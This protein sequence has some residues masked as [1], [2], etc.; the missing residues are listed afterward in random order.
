MWTVYWK[1]MRELMRDTKVL[2]FTIFIPIVAIPALLFGFSYLAMI[3]SDRALHADV[4]YAVFG[5]A[6]GSAL[7]T[8]LAR[9]PRWHRVAL[10]DAAQIKP[11]IEDGRIGFALVAAPDFDARTG[12]GAQ[13]AIGLVFNGSGSGGGT[14]RKRVNALIDAHNDAVRAQAGALLGIDAAR[15]GFLL[16]PVR[17][18]ERPT[19]DLRE[20][21]GSLLGGLLPYFLTI[22]CLLAAMY[23][24]IDLGAGEKERGTLETLLLAP[25]TRT[26]LVVAK[27][28]VLFTVGL[29][30][31]LLM[32]ISMGFLL[33]VFGSELDPGIAAIA[34]AIGPGD[35]VMIALMLVP[36]AAIFAS[37]LLSLSI[38][39]KSY[40]EASGMMQPLVILS[41]MPTLLALV[42]GVELN[43]L[44][45]AVPITNIALAIRELLKGTMDYAMFGMILASTT[46]I[47]GLLLAACQWWFK[48]EGVLFRD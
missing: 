1:E 8:R 47:A 35:Q 10:R 28:L 33:N 12:A 4:N 48:Q 6:G 41:I 37:V 30:S 36:S 3:M 22:V 29:T 27:F 17:I 40:K 42:P 15:V 5:V 34:T 38:Y 14:I 16:H 13:G 26:A 7:D 19:S 31:A 20:R 9:E 23:P 21:A 44:W 11:A 39:A 18:E 43:W 25:L 32:V 46:L 45:A 24:A 2:L